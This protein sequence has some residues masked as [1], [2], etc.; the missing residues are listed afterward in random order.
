MELSELDWTTLRERGAASHTPGQADA[1]AQLCSIN[2]PS[3]LSHFF[4]SYF[5]VGFFLDQALCSRMI[6]I[7]S[8]QTTGFESNF[9]IVQV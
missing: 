2:I 1:W 9:R 8:I 6:D 4:N 3:L 7:W 5:F